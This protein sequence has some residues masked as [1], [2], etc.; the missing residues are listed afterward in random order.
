[1]KKANHN[2]FQYVL[3]N[4]SDYMYNQLYYCEMSCNIKY[5]VVRQFSFLFPKMYV[6]EAKM[7]VKCQITCIRLG[8]HNCMNWT[9]NVLKLIVKLRNNKYKL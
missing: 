4:F 2:V 9:P 6:I 7:V 8:L 1:M 3:E 5:R